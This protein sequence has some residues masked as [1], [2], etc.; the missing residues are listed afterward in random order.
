MQGVSKH[1]PIHGD[2]LASNLVGPASKVTQVIDRQGN[3]CSSCP[4]DRLAVVL[5]AK[6]TL[7]IMAHMLTTF[8]KFPSLR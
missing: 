3:V 8:H 6:H 5:N 4:S 1:G 7:S 2:G